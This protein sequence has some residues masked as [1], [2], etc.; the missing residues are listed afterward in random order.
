MGAPLASVLERPEPD[1]PLAF[2]DDELCAQAM[3]ADPDMPADPDA[4]PF[5]S[6]GPVF[7]TLLPDWYMPTPTAGARTR[8]HAVV[9][10]LVIASF[11]LINALG[12]CITYGHLMV[13]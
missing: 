12:L 5:A 3:A 2:T 7:P 9:V 10:V 1:D 6:G 8:W 13:G 11:V 4:V